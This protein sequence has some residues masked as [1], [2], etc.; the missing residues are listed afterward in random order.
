MDL[1]IYMR[2]GKCKRYQLPVHE[3]IAATCIIM[4]D[5]RNWLETAST[6]PGCQSTHWQLYIE[7][8]K[9]VQ[10]V[11]SSAGSKVLEEQDG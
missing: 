11:E 7:P 1:C 5:I 2:C 4:L 10:V 8:A 9:D 6:C 3:R